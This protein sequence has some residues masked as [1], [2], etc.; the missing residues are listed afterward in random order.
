MGVIPV[1]DISKTNVVI[2]KTEVVDLKM[3]IVNEYSEREIRLALGLAYRGSEGEIIEK[4]ITKSG[5]A[6]EDYVKH[7]YDLV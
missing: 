7:I 6:E 2:N 1:L 3:D 4:P 5:L